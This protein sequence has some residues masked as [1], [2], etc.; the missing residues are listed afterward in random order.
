MI[1]ADRAAVLLEDR[2]LPAHRVDASADVARI[3]VARDQLE[4]HLLAAASDQEGEPA[5]TG[6]GRFRTDLA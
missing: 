4:S 3:P 1:A 5:C 6:A 2:L